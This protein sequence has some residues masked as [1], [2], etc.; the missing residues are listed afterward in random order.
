VTVASVVV[1]MLGPALCLIGITYWAQTAI[2]AMIWLSIGLGINT[3]TLVGV[4][5]LHLDI[6]SREFAGLVYALGNTAGNI[7][8]LVAIPITGWMQP[9]W[10]LIFWLGDKAPPFL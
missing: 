3:A 7:G 4:S 8:G 2:E 6:E 1:G 10:E 5:V 9:H